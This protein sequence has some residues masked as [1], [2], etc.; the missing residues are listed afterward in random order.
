MWQKGLL[1]QWI[2]YNFNA[3]VI[4]SMLDINTTVENQE[5]KGKIKVHFF[6]IW[7]KAAYRSLFKYSGFPLCISISCKAKIAHKNHIQHLFLWVGI[8]KDKKKIIS[9]Q[10]ICRTTS[11][12]SYKTPSSL[13]SKGDSLNP[14]LEYTFSDLKHLKFY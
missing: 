7:L 9:P 13:E 11:L 6:T 1:G 5:Q 2:V 12:T 8:M 10:N 4:V 3:P 14:S